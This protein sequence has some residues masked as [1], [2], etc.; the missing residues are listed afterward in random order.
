[1]MP[2]DIGPDIQTLVKESE[3][4]SNYRERCTVFDSTGWALEDIVTMDLFREYAAEFKVG[5]EIQL[6]TISTDHRNPYQFLEDCTD[7]DVD[8]SIGRKA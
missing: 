2:E 6:E 3:R 1:M 4:F 8:G 7:A 5:S